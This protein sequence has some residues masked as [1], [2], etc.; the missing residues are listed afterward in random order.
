M[1]VKEVI[2]KLSIDDLY[3]LKAI[4]KKQSEDI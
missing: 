1:E 3:I 4:A 2:L